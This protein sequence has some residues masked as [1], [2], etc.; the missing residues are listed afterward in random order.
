[1]KWRDTASWTTK[2][3]DDDDDDES[4][5]D[6]DSTSSSGW[7]RSLY[8]MWKKDDEFVTE[9]CIT[10]AIKDLV[11]DAAVCGEVTDVFLSLCE[12]NKTDFNSST[13]DEED[14][15]RLIV[16]VEPD[17]GS[18]VNVEGVRTGDGELGIF[19]DFKKGHDVAEF[20][21][22]LGNVTVDTSF[23]QQK[24]TI[25]I[26]DGGVVIQNDISK[27]ECPADGLPCLSSVCSLWIMMN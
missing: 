4:D 1:M 6:S 5:S 9:V 8:A 21:L 16:S 13:I 2:E 11:P 20:V 27:G 7:D 10:Y 22:C 15:S 17:D 3:R 19:V 24:E 12:N 18:I 23:N 14:L 25:E 26:G